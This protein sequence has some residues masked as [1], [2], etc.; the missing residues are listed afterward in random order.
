MLYD[1][2]VANRYEIIDRAR[3]RVR[4]RAAS[5][6]SEAKLE[7]G[8]PLFLSQLADALRPVSSSSALHLVTAQDDQ[9]PYMQISNSAGLHGHELLKNGFTVAQ[10]V[11]GY[12]DVCQ[13]VTELATERNAAITSQDFHVFNVAWMTP[14]RER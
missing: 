10:V 12:G 5:K 4:E 8:V 1:F 6:S 9:H 13:I 7:H 11:H 2:I 14:S 3:Q